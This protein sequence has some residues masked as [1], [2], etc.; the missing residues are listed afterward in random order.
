MPLLIDI[1]K[2][3]IINQLMKSGT[4]NVTEALERLAD[5][6]SRVDI[7]SLSFVEPVDIAAE[8]GTEKLYSASIHLREPPYGVFLL[9]FPRETGEEM[10]ALMT[11]TPVAGEFNQLQESA[12]Q[13]MCN[14]LTSGSI[15]GIANTLG[16]TIDMETP[17]LRYSNGADVA[18]QTL[19]HVRKDSLSIVLDS[20]IDV[21]DEDAA[22][23]VR[24][25][26]VP[27][28]GAFVNLIDHLDVEEISDRAESEGELP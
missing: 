13:E 14:I 28:P 18:E 22:F 9:T 26:L 20:M 17:E 27:D 2:L 10:A 8:I 16:T 4:E 19:S 7:K 15:D 3:R 11:G 6:E 23:K 5:V 21:A 24:V 25:F 12:L 1:R